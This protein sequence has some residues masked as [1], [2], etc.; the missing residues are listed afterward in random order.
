M[1]VH[2]YAEVDAEHVVAHLDQLDH[3]ERFVA[4][5]SVLVDAGPD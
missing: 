1:L 5:L 3:V 4:C 2:L